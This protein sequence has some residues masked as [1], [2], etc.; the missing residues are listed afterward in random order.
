MNNIQDSSVNSRLYNT[1]FDSNTPNKSVQVVTLK[2]KEIEKEQQEMREILRN[3]DFSCFQLDLG[4]TAN[5]TV[6]IPV[7]K[8]AKKL[9]RPKTNPS[10]FTSVLRSEPIVENVRRRGEVGH[11]WTKEDYQYIVKLAVKNAIKINQVYTGSALARDI[12]DDFNRSIPGENISLRQ[13]IASFTNR[14]KA[15][16]LSV[17]EY[18]N[19]LVNVQIEALEGLKG[20]DATAVEQEM[21]DRIDRI[22][23]TALEKNRN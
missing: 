15:K 8:T 13:L 14:V 18:K 7:Q 10:P 5:P 20:K 19:T 22:F 2:D 9:S 12:L 6:N 11:K 17:E 1:N 4:S 21:N 3:A 16:I 23:Q